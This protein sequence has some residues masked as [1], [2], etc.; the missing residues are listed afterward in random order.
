MRPAAE[1]LAGIPKVRRFGPV[2]RAQVVQ[3]LRPGPFLA[4][5][6]GRKERLAEPGCRPPLARVPGADLGDEIGQGY[7]ECEPV[8]ADPAGPGD[9][10]A[11]VVDVFGDP[12]GTEP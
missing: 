4:A 5:L 8:C 10:A 3:I 7:P 9:R 11:L 6:V 12:R 1:A 2:H